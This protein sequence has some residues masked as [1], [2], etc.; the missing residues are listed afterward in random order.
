MDWHL[1]LRRGI[2]FLPTTAVVERGLYRDIEPVAVVPLSNTGGV[3]AAI[4]ATMARGNPP[5]PH[6]AGG[7]YPKPV[8]LKYAG[9]RS[10]S[11]FARGAVT[12]NIEQEDGSYRIIGYRRHAKGYWERDPDNQ[13]V[14]PNGS[15]LDNV[16]DR[17]IEILQVAERS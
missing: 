16:I 8:L 4:A 5:A 11:E 17:M 14:F 12:W 13:I 3:R 2:L 7:K 9:V 15:T 10:W 1:Y 6:F